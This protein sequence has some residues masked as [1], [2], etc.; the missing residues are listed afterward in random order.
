LQLG[1][2]GD[3]VDR[4]AA[5]VEIDD[6]VVDGLVRR[7]VEVGTAD[8][9]GDVGDRVLRDQHRPEHGLLGCHV[10]RRGPVARRRGPLARGVRRGAVAPVVH[11]RLG[12]APRVVLGDAHPCSF[13]RLVR[14]Q[15]ACSD[16]KTVHRHPG[17]PDNIAESG[18]I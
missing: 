8:H 1:G 6:R 14:I 3:H 17:G 13:N 4:L 15:L 12:H 5:A 11:R 16:S 18:R 10:L 9:L 2:D 7:S